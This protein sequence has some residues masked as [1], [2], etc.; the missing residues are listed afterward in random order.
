MHILEAADVYA[1]GSNRPLVLVELKLPDIGLP[2]QALGDR[3]PGLH[4]R[5]PGR[6]GFRW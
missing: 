4:R 3:R 1:G 2:D 5:R 6:R